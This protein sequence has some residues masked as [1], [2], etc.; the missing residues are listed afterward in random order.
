MGPDKMNIE[1]SIGPDNLLY[2]LDKN[3]ERYIGEHKSGIPDGEG[4][5]TW[6]GGYVYVGSFKDGFRHG[7]GVFT[8]PSGKKQTGYFFKGKFT[9]TRRHGK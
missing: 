2:T 1:K 3:G 8:Y 9:K 5:Q 6:P 4:Q 7:W